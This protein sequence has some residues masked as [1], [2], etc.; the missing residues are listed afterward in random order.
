MKMEYKSC[1]KTDKEV[2]DETAGSALAQ[3]WNELPKHLKKE[4]LGCLPLEDVHRYRCVCKPWNALLSSNKFINRI[5]AESPINQQPWLV[6]SD[7]MPNTPCMA[8][9]FYTRTWKSCFSL[10]FLEKQGTVKVNWRGS[11][12]GVVLVDLPFG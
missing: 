9:C 7:D 11:V 1:R 5:W 4:I 12:P 8:F 10:S 2:A 3:C 6:L